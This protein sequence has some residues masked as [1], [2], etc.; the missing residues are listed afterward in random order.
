MR[1]KTREQSGVE[2]EAYTIFFNGF[3]CA[4]FTGTITLLFI[5]FLGELPSTLP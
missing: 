1:Q 2:T 5:E 4:Y 3:S